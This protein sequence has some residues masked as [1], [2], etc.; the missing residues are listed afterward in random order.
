[1][2]RPKS[3]NTVQVSFMIPKEWIDLARELATTSSP[4]P[5]IKVTRAD[6]LR[7]ALGRGLFSM[8]PKKRD[9]VAR[10]TMATRR[11]AP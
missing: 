9:R 11:G 1:M 8:R 10:R 6:I 3:E 7:T 2:P 4:W 5:G